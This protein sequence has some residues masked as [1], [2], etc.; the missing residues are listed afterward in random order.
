MSRLTSHTKYSEDELV[1]DL[2]RVAGIYEEPSISQ[3]EYEEF[4]IAS[5]WTFKRRFGSW[6]NAHR[7]AGLV[8]R[9]NKSCPGVNAKYGHLSWDDIEKSRRAEDAA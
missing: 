3:L 4:G 1:E 6:A 5:A 9:P 8:P 7:A 2:A